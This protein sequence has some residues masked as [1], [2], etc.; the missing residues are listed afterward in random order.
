MILENFRVDGPALPKSFPEGMTLKGECFDPEKH[1]CIELPE[2]IKDL[3]FNNVPYPFKDEDQKTDRNLAYSRPFRLLSKAGVKAARDSMVHGKVNC[4]DR[5]PKFIRALGYTSNWHR[6]FAFSP[7]VLGVLSGIARDELRPHGHLMNISHTNVGEIGTGRAVDKWH[8]DSVD[9]VL[10]VVL[11][12]LTDMKG[13]ALQVVQKPDAND[14]TFENLQKKGIPPELIETIKY[15]E[16]M[17]GYAILMQG[18]K[19]LHTVN[20]VLAGKE[21]RISLVNSYAPNRPF[22]YD[23]TKYHSHRDG[24]CD[25]E[26]IASVEFARHKAWRIQGQMKYILDELNFGTDRKDIIDLLRAAENELKECSDDLENK[27]INCF[28]T[29]E[30]TNT[31]VDAKET[32]D[33]EIRKAK[34]VK[35]S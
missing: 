1:L 3:T 11:S 10:V 20:E 26:S 24:F 29:I 30:G 4:T 35:S 13:G 27:R 12:D 28:Q 31:A 6:G 9:Y 16:G 32:D 21:A 22:A 5:A 7:E 17:P 8:T 19:I 33:D 23:R 34:R 15:S 25:G 2:T 18:S 14:G